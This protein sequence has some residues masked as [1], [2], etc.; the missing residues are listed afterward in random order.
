MRTHRGGSAYSFRWMTEHHA[1]RRIKI[2][3]PPPPSLTLRFRRLGPLAFSPSP[4]HLRSSP[5]RV[6]IKSATHQPSGY[7]RS[8]SVDRL[9][10]RRCFVRELVAFVARLHEPSLVEYLRAA[11]RKEGEKWRE[12]HVRPREKR[13]RDRERE[14]L[15]IPESR[16][17]F[18]LILP[19]APVICNAPLSVRNS[20]HFKRIA[21]GNAILLSL[22]LFC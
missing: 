1:P 15:A 12:V 14:S 22:F 9:R 10:Y 2:S 18:S 4:L 5:G 6:G 20:D 21:S 11:P 19:S 16:P 8:L 13:Q 17:M 3:E 7:L